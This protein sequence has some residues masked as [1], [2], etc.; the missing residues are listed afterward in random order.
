MK[1]AIC[2]QSSLHWINCTVLSLRHKDY[3]SIYISQNM[4]AENLKANIQV[5]IKIITVVNTIYCVKFKLSEGEYWENER[6]L[7]CKLRPTLLLK[8]NTR[9]YGITVHLRYIYSGYYLGYI[10]TVLLFKVRLLYFK[11][12]RSAFIAI[13]GICRSLDNSYLSETFERVFFKKL[14]CLHT[15]V[16]CFHASAIHKRL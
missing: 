10:Q 13:F 1:W 15:T 6:Y 4:F 9:K 8:L 2:G 11:H 5:S 14:W 12:L 16:H 3:W 7:H